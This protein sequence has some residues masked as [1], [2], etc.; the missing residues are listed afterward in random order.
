MLN[1]SGVMQTPTSF[2]TPA[3]SM[4]MITDFW[5]RDKSLSPE[6][7]TGL[8][9]AIVKKIVELHHGNIGFNSKKGFGSEFYFSIPISQNS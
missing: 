8:G 9:L 4:K 2:T 6:G 3:S 5:V 1:F 7:K